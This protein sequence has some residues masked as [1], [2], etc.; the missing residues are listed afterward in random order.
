MRELSFRS[1]DLIPKRGIDSLLE[2]EK[3]KIFNL[4]IFVKVEIDY[5]EHLQDTINLN[6]KVIENL[7][8][9]PFP[10]I[11][12]GGRELN[13]IF[14]DAQLWQH[15][16][17]GANITIDNFRGL[18]EKLSLRF[19]FGFQNYFNF[20]Y[21]RPFLDK[22]KIWGMTLNTNYR[23]HKNVSYLTVDGRTIEKDAFEGMQ[24]EDIAF[25]LAFYR[26]QNFYSTHRFGLSLQ[27]TTVADSI[28]ILSPN[29]LG[30]GKTKTFI[31]TLRYE[32]EYKFT[33]RDAYP[34]KGHILKAN[35]IKYG[36]P[37]VSDIDM[38]EVMT[39]GA[40]HFDLGKGFYASHSLGLRLRWGRIPYLYLEG[41]GYSNEFKVRGYEI[42][43][44]NGRHYA[45][46][47]NEL[48]WKILDKEIKLNLPWDQFSTLP[49][50][51]IPKVFLD[52]GYAYLDIEEYIAGNSFSNKPLIGWGA[53]IDVVGAYNFVMRFEYS[54]TNYI[55][56]K[57]Q[58][59][60][61]G[62]F[63]N[64]SSGI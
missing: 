14:L 63:F 27:Q 22:K 58:G 29:Y 44:A 56:P 11:D 42:Y 15:V 17:Y 54:M 61:H 2:L 36:V 25:R 24:R 39:Y 40:R 5:K 26:R 23:E 43:V 12:L 19:L 30:D 32:W 45:T 59:F 1:Y 47:K 50:W 46:F 10:E 16:R 21:N 20:E 57:T 28:S 4:D 62:F 6:I 49:I 55:D 48:K 34:L 18:R 53:G 7:Y 8:I 33:N 3:N 9:K 41:L 51:I 52:M 35:V 60:S 38:G 31:P 64:I 37:T 13:E